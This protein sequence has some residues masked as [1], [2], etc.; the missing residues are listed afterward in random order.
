[1]LCPL[2]YWGTIPDIYRRLRDEGRSLPEGPTYEG[3]W[4]EA[5][6]GR[7]FQLSRTQAFLLISARGDVRIGQCARIRGL[8]A[9]AYAIFP[10]GVTRV[11]Q[12]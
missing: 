7:C 2:S 11:E 1:M 3:S 5:G 12:S 9:T 10:K 8:D 6:F 4:I